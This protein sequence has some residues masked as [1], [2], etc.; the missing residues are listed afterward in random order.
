MVYGSL[1]QEQLQCSAK[2]VR[3][4]YSE[5]LLHCAIPDRHLCKPV[6]METIRDSRARRGPA[7]MQLTEFSLCMRNVTCGSER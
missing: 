4:R 7:A 2:Q 1:G 3:F 6:D 5:D